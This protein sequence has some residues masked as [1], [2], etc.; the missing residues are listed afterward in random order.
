MY[1]VHL[2]IM[3][4]LSR[5]FE[6]ERYGRVVLEKAVRDGTTVRALLEDIC[7]GNPAFRDVLYDAKTGRLAGY[8]GV[9]LNGRFLELSGGLEAKVEPGDTIRVMPGF[10]GG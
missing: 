2:E 8:I 3:P 4:W 9:V 7:T 1:C 6:A 5:Y 10:S